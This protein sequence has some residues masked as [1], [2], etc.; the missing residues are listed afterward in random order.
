MSNLGNQISASEST[1]LSNR[2][3][4]LSVLGDGGFSKT[5]LV[6]DTQM[7]SARKCVLK[8]LKPV[9]DNAQVY[10]TICDRFQREAAIL[11]QLGENNNHI[12][13]LYANFSEGDHFY[14]VEE[15]IDGETLT[16]KVQREG[17]LS[18][19]VVREILCGLLPTIAYIHHRQIVHRD[20]KPDNIIL[21]TADRNPVLIDFG[22]VK[23]TMGT[24]VNST[25]NNSHS[26]IVGTPG[27]MPSEQLAGRPIYA[28]DLY[29]LGM[30]A[31]FLLTGKPP[32]ELNTDSLTGEVLWV[33]FAPQV[34][35]G[36]ATVLNRA[37][38]INP[39]LRFT[40]AEE[41]LTAVLTLAS[42][43]EIPAAGNLQSATVLS[44][45]PPVSSQQTQFSMPS[46]M[47]LSQSVPPGQPVTQAHLYPP[48]MNAVPTKA[49]G[50]WQKAMIMGGMIGVSILV[51]ALVLRGQVPGFTS[52][53]EEDPK[54]SPSPS[55]IAKPSPTPQAPVPA[56]QPPAQP[57]IPR[58]GAIANANATVVGEPGVKNIRSGPGTGFGVLLQGYPGDRIQVLSVTNNTDGHPWYRVALPNGGEGWIAGQLVEPD[59]A[60]SSPP[61]MIAP[62]PPSSNGTNATIIGEPGYKNVRTGPGTNYRAQHKAYPGDRVRIINSSRDSSGSTWHEVFFPISG[63]RG[64]MA[65]QLIRQD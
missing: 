2:Y 49:S 12:P 61:V 7:P 14:L 55:P 41:M 54:P 18:E 11:E 38:H 22:A 32:Q 37:I 20:I 56:A 31:I 28:S 35:A 50:E 16:Q 29:G 51:G 39:Q 15:W 48:H 1:L 10:Q 19:T 52:V 45:A 21:R 40:T 23:E 34:S 59:R 4:V 33:N 3:Q 42:S 5:F 13:R 43:G 27:Y 53:V 63:A 62:P 26:I 9:S 30:T 58:L 6:E 8:Q 60:I 17:A 64:W 65:G 36:F 47:P 25:G 46:S 57:A 44:T 24:V